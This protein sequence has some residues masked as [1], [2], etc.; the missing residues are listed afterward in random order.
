VDEPTTFVR[1]DEQAMLGSTVRDLLGSTSDGDRVRELS[2]TTDAID[3]TVWG[4]LADVG[5]IGPMI[6]EAF[7]GAGFGMTEVA[8]VCEELG[9]A[10][11]PIPYLSSVVGAAAILAGGDDGQKEMWLPRI[12]SG[13]TIATVAVFEDPHDMEVTSAHTV[14]RLSDGGWVI[15]GRKRFVTD[16]P[17]ADL[18]VVAA[19]V[20]GRTHVFVV[21]RDTEGLGVEPVN[22]LDA[23]RP[24]ADVVLN[25]V[26]VPEEAMLAAKAGSEVVR[27]AI[28][29]AVVCAASEQVGGAQYCLETAVEYAKTR[30][31]FG[32]AIGSFQAVK[33]MCADMLV[34]VEHARSVAWHAAATIDDPDEARIAVP[35]AKSVCSDAYLKA[36]G[37]TIQILGGIGFTWE[38]SAHLYYKR[39][40]ALSL[41]FGSVDA[42]RDRLADALE[43]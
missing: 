38:H 36:A 17:N 20:D 15:D 39:A 42:Y 21:P 11:S 41:L 18:F 8:V 16:A 43:I 13:D 6:P 1:T 4:G 10:L 25:N 28:D 30:H 29:V 31:Q 24:L 2:L 23:T 3:R 32:R 12:V 27:S 22:A 40:K 26:T 14:A 5:V 7:G 37:D 19:S 35:L 33:H 9:R 34:A